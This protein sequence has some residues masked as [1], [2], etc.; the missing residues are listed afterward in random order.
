MPEIMEITAKPKF[1]TDWQLKNKKQKRLSIIF[2]ENVGEVL[3]AQVDLHAVGS[4][5]LIFGNDECH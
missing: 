4:A 3:F 5:Q 1:C 2:F